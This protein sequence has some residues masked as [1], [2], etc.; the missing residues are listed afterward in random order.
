MLCWTFLKS[1][2]V[3]FDFSSNIID[4]GLKQLMVAESQDATGSR[5]DIYTG[6]DM[7]IT[8]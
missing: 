1:T 8:G 7:Q 6:T 4:I 3:K 5:S 2:G